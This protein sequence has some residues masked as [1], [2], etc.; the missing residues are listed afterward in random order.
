MLFRRLPIDPLNLLKVL[1]SEIPARAKIDKRADWTEATKQVLCELGAENG[2]KVHASTHLG[3]ERL[4]EW[5]LDVVWYSSEPKGGIELAVESELG[6]K[7]DVLEDFEKLMCVKA[8]L[9]LLMFEQGISDVVHDLEGYLAESEQHIEGE[10]YLLIDFAY[11]THRCYKFVVPPNDGKLRKVEVK[12][13]LLLSGRD[14]AQ[15]ASAARH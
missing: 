12:F 10:T 9:K 1:V 8:P 14:R 15:N 4:S 2:F 6:T 3:N 7:N 5:L 13:D 11:G